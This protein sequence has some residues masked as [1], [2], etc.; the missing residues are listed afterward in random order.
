MEKNENK[1]QDTTNILFQK[2]I[3]GSSVEDLSIHFKIV[4]PN[5]IDPTIIA[6]VVGIPVVVIL[7]ITG[8]IIKKKLKASNIANTA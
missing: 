1:V 4:S 7:G 8:F 3:T 2:T 6:M 5:Y